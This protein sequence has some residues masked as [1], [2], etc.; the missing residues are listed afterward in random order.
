[1]KTLYLEKRGCDFFKGDRINELSNI[2]NYRVCTHYN[3]SKDCYR[4][5]G[6]DGKLYF[7]EFTHWTKYEYRYTHKRTGKELKKPIKELINENAL[8]VNTEYEDEKGLSWR[9]LKL[10]EEINNLNLDFTIDGI[11]K[12]V[13]YISCEQY[14]K[15][16]FI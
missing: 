9:N 14:D 4:I 12:V 5:K 10:E 1:M 3:D 15:V 8:Y 7:L 11:L 16:E 2:G 6:K 13:N